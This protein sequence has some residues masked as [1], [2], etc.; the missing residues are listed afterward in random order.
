MESLESFGTI[1]PYKNQ[2]VIA[3]GD[4]LTGHEPN[5]GKELWRW[6]TWNPGHKE[7]WWR[8][9]PSPVIGEG[10]ILV[11]APKKAPIYAVET[12][13]RGFHEGDNGLAWN[14]Q[15]QP[16]L[17]S[18]VPTPLFYQNKFFILSDLK[19]SLSRVNPKN[20][21][22]EWTIELPGKYK[23]R[24]LRLVETERFIL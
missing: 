21:K 17:T 20:G 2:L 3:G 1:I 12:D 24:H 6:G 9:V 19:K 8:L 11:C 10:V 18:D 15:A 7:Q 22:V 16:S 14:T 5:S 23:W 13:L 4:V